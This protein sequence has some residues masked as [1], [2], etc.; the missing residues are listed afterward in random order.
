MRINGGVSEPVFNQFDFSVRLHSSIE[1]AASSVSAGD[2]ANATWSGFPNA[3]QAAGVGE[4]GPQWETSWN[5]PANSFA[6]VANQPVV[7]AVQFYTNSIVDFG[8]F[9]ICETRGPN[10]GGD[11]LAGPFFPTPGWVSTQA[12]EETFFSGELAINVYFTPTTTCTAP[13]ITTQPVGRGL[14]PTDSGLFTVDASGTVPAFRWQWQP[15]GVGTEFVN[16]PQ[17]TI[18]NADGQ[19]CFIVEGVSTASLRITRIL[20]E[21]YHKELNLRCNVQNTCGS[22]TS[23]IAKFEMLARPLITTQPQSATTCQSSQAL[24]SVADTAGNPT[25]SRFQWQWRTIGDADW[26]NM[27]D[28]PNTDPLGGP[29]RFTAAGA[30]AATVTVS[31][32]SG[33]SGTAGS[34]W[35]KRCIVTSSCGSVNSNTA[36]LTVLEACCDSIDFNADSLFPD[37]ADLIDFLSVL[38]GGPCSTN[39]CSDID[40]NNDGLFPD[41]NDLIAFLTVLAGGN[42]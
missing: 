30:R 16:I 12:R 25:P 38:A 31:N 13:T 17:G 11:F 23:N 36:T 2:L 8:S 7:L 28:G 4:E 40:F 26:V 22:V 35:E 1:N 34:H 14:C 37:D 33:G 6:L 41:D 15:G 10:V 18:N 27:V 9:N 19:P 3:I 29:N 42:C 39:T 21:Q 32:A 5:L 20:D 24:F